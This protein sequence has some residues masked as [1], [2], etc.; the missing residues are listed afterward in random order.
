M[1]AE[2]IREGLP[3]MQRDPGETKNMKSKLIAG[4]AVAGAALMLA[5]TAYA[6]TTFKGHGDLVGNASA[7]HS[8]VDGNNSGMGYCTLTPGAQ[9]HGA[10][11]GSVTVVM[12]TVNK[13]GCA[14]T[15]LAANSTYHV[16][17]YNGA[18]FA[19]SRKGVYNWNVDCMDGASGT[20]KQDVTTDANGGV[21]T[22][23]SLGTGTNNIAGQDSAICIS[24][25]G[26]FVGSQIP[27]HIVT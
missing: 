9:A 12:S 6:C 17:Y 1:A 26:G 3:L 13:A 20:F 4:A 11:T 8:I 24:D 15:K 25:T 16:R 18:G 22:T 2:T 21:T 14:S 27:V 10:T 19:T 7:T 5:S 23:V